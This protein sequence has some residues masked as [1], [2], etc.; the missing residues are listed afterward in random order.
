MGDAA[1]P[2]SASTVETTTTV[3]LP[4]ATVVTFTAGNPL[5][6]YTLSAGTEAKVNTVTTV[7][8]AATPPQPPTPVQQAEGSTFR[9]FALASLVLFLFAGILAY[10]QHYL[11]ALKLAL[12][13][14]ALPVLDKLFSSE[15][16]LIVGIALLASGI[17]FVVAYYVMK[18]K[19]VVKSTVSSVETAVK[20]EVQKVE[21]KI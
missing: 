13:G 11:A 12:A 7:L 10:L 4:P 5:P 2:A 14:I 8:N 19:M 1:K 20:S 3:P 9:W 15:L 21:Q 16:A 6:Q 17:V 18:N